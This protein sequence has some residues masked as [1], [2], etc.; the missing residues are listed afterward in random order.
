[1]DLFL[2]QPLD[3]PQAANILISAYES[4]SRLPSLNGH[5]SWPSE[6]MR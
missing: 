2:R 5:D 1:M 6:I 4:L 3:G